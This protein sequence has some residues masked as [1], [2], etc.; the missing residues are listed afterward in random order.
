MKKILFTG[1]RYWT[2]R[3]VVL[4]AMRTL[5]CPSIIIH[6]AAQGLDTLASQVAFELG[7]HPAGMKANWD[8]YQ[9]A[10]GPRRN[11]A[12]LALAPDEVWFFHNDLQNSKRTKDCVLQAE[13]AGIP[14]MDGRLVAGN[15]IRR[16]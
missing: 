1:S 13:A 7:H 12:M 6:G 11:T 10:A 3:E 2:D 16:T 14:V 5:V 15:G 4:S 8:L 9:L